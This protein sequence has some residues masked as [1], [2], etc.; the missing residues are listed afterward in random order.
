[1]ARIAE[2]KLPEWQSF[3]QPG[4]RCKYYTNVHVP[5]CGEMSID[6]TPDPW[7]LARPTGAKAGRL[8]NG[9]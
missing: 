5:I 3:L 4:I 2:G 9:K 8:L 7:Q 1:V 6:S